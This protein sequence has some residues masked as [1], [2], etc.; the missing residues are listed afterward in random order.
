MAKKQYI[1]KDIREA[2]KLRDCVCQACG[3]ND[4]REMGHIVA[5]SNFGGIEFENLMLLCDI[6]NTA[7]GNVTVNIIKAATQLSGE[8]SR[9]YTDNC[10]DYNR[11]LW[12]TYIKRAKT[13]ANMYQKVLKFEAEY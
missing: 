3:T 11:K 10:R 9:D 6:C 7:Q 1:S 13:V 2:I 8:L 5:E 4:A 12:V